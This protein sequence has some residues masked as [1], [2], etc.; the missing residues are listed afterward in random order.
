MGCSSSK[1]TVVQLHP[2]KQQETNA[3]E[4]KRKANHA[5]NSKERNGAGG[6]A[7]SSTRHNTKGPGD[8][9]LSELSLSTL[10]VSKNSSG[11][12]AGP[13]PSRRKNTIPPRFKKGCHNCEDEQVELTVSCIA[14]GDGDFPALFCAVCD[15]GLHKPK[16]M[17]QHARRP[18]KRLTASALKRKAKASQGSVASS[19]RASSAHENK[20]S[21]QLGIP[22][23]SPTVP[24]SL[25]GTAS[26]H[27]RNASSPVA[28][29]ISKETPQIGRHQFSYASSKKRASPDM[30]GVVHR[31]SLIASLRHRQSRQSRQSSVASS[32]FDGLSNGSVSPDLTGRAA[33]PT[34]GGKRSGKSTGE[35]YCVNVDSLDLRSAVVPEND[36][37]ASAFRGAVT[38][39][40]TGLSHLAAISEHG[41]L[42]M[43]GDNDQGQL[44]IVSSEQ[45]V[46]ESAADADDDDDDNDDVL[47]ALSDSDADSDKCRAA[48]FVDFPSLVTVRLGR[49]MQHVTTV[50][51]GHYH[52]L[53]ITT[54]GHLFSWG[55]G[56]MGVLGHGNDMSYQTPKHIEAFG[57]ELGQYAKDLRPVYAACGAYNS[58]VVARLQSSAGSP[59]R[60]H[61][62]M[63]VWGAGESGQMGNGKQ[64]PE[65]VPKL[66]SPNQF[67]KSYPVAVEFGTRHLVTV[68]ND[69]SIYSWGDN[70]FGQLGHGDPSSTH[71]PQKQLI[72][73]RVES[74]SKKNVHVKQ[75]GCGER[76]TT[77]LASDG[78]LWSWGSGETHQI[79]ILDNVDQFEP[80]QVKI[81][82]PDSDGKSFVRIV[83]ICV[84]QNASAAV[85]DAG[86]VWMWGW[87]IESAVPRLIDSWQA[88]FMQQVS[89]GANE[90]VVALTKTVQETYFWDFNVD[91]DDA[92]DQ[93]VALY[94][95]LQGQW[96]KSISC[97]RAHQVVVHNDGT[98]LVWGENDDGQLGTGNDVAF[99]IPI[100]LNIPFS[101]EFVLCGTD[102]TV[103][104]TS[105][106]RVLTWGCGTMGR[107]GHGSDRD[108]RKPTPVEAFAG[109]SMK[110]IGVGPFNSAAITADG[111]LYVWGSSNGGQL[112]LGDC[113]PRFE[114][115]R[116]RVFCVL[117][118]VHVSQLLSNHIH[119][120]SFFIYLFCFCFLTWGVWHCTCSLHLLSRS[121]ILLLEL[122]SARHTR[123]YARPQVRYIVVVTMSLAN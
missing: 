22:N 24:R 38:S 84:G 26:N 90:T 71:L 93:T 94:K 79:G 57:A 105:C 63:Y 42:Y 51:C 54:N 76:H 7:A 1:A 48:N 92:S 19:P 49:T 56:M 122:N 35:V 102:H 100:S 78:S 9:T 28:I 82:T 12:E 96:L 106:D 95:P 20:T 111:K 81:P 118:F 37:T 121:V 109:K 50:A 115:S 113:S 23:S 80:V 60:P 117:F 10:S 29:S 66:V 75:V 107:L 116:K 3:A 25:G 53:A 55:G 101:V 8:D 43:W 98:L 27:Q 120:M 73:K 4:A 72:P 13:G 119:V 68:Q 52:T 70:E 36:I 15:A 21:S 99:S 16:K 41:M 88:K 46:H 40:A 39:V 114:V 14:C 83:Q 65:M 77:V 69:G 87:A 5:N 108:C 44:G 32:L 64:E 104:L 110:A 97:G 30:A 34:D 6:G 18:Y 112:G 59:H 47:D 61:Y 86:R 67:G 62:R 89:I 45:G 103:A 91:Q 17:R 58:A 85:S 33:S 31:T 2:D 123:P 74:L 11:V